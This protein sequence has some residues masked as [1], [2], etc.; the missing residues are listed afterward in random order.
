MAI[1]RERDDCQHFKNLLAE[2]AAKHHLA[3]YHWALMP[4]H[5]HHKKYDS[6]GFLFQGR[7]KSQPVQED[8]L[9]VD[10][11]APRGDQA[12]VKKLVRKQGRLLPRRRGGVK[13]FVT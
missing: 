3:I 4:N 8:R 10:V 9:F 5:F 12:F 6:E 1:F 7:F 2:Y 11:D 13:V